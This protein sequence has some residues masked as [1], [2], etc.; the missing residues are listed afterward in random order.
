MV[1]VNSNFFLTLVTDQLYFMYFILESHQ[2][3][4]EGTYC[5]YERQFS[6]DADLHNPS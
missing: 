5:R 4:N 6:L 1:Y 3:A 2:F